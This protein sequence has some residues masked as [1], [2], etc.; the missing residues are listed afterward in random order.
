MSK[1]ILLKPKSFFVDS[2]VNAVDAMHFHGYAK[3]GGEYPNSNDYRIQFDIDLPLKVKKNVY[4]LAKVFC[5]CGEMVVLDTIAE[6]LAL[7]FGIAI[8]RVDF[9]IVFDFNYHLL[10]VERYDL[11]MS[12]IDQA[13]G[14]LSIRVPHYYH[15]QMPAAWEINSKYPNSGVEQIKLKEGSREK[16]W[17]CRV[18]SDLFE[19]APIY[20]AGGFVMDRPV[21]DVLCPYLNFN[22]FVFAEGTY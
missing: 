21:F 14:D 17:N 20:H 18:S 7:K 13:N 11:A 12:Q 3:R 10:S 22:Y 15:I 9:E 19:N 5:P 1:F 8:S 2:D 6:E 4:Q 16:L